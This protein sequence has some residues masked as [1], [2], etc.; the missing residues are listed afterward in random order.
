MEY[1]EKRWL[2]IF[3]LLAI[4]VTS[5][6]YALAFNQQ[7]DDWLFSG[8]LIGVED[9]NSYIAKMLRG[10]Q[11]DWLFESPYS[12]ED[13]SGAL[14]YLPYLLL[15]KLLGPDGQHD[16]LLLLFHVF[17]IVALVLLC[18]AS[19]SFL[20]FFLKKSSSRRLGIFL[21]TF[22]G[23]L[24]WIL[25]LIGQSNWL[26]SL[27]LEFY[28][29]ETFGFLAFFTLLHLALG[30]ALMLWGILLYLK[31]GTQRVQGRWII[32]LWLSMAMVHLLNAVIGLL[33]IGLHFIASTVLERRNKFSKQ[34]QTSN[35]SSSILFPLLGAGI[36][37][38]LNLYLLARDPYLQAWAAQNQIPSPHFLHYVLAYGLL[39]PFAI[40]G[41]RHLSKQEKDSSLLLITWLLAL[42]VLLYLPLGLQRRF[43]E[44]IWLVLVVLA[45]AAFESK[46]FSKRQRWK[47]IFAAAFPASLILLIGTM[48]VA[49]DPKPPVFYSKDEVNLFNDLHDR[50]ENND[51]VLSNYELGNLIP[52]WA[53]VR[54]IIGHGPESVGLSALQ[55]GIEAFLVDQ[56]VDYGSELFSSYDIDY[57]VAEGESSAFNSFGFDHIATYGDFLL[58]EKTSSGD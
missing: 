39:L 56:N 22:G 58:F 6:P 53:P 21:V 24:G 10:G 26:G 12:A 42:P 5:L 19:Y 3:I 40:I 15:G 51:L 31:S 1:K 4:I 2:L 14:L 8:F 54:V 32:L 52:A 37:I 20:S 29:P 57:I 11:G 43:A 49:G 30:R 38:V 55:P 18:L 50:A 47:W 46:R 28:S 35:K 9:G 33:V 34:V 23:G 17:R 48:Q 27:P 16:Q 25:L 13:Q 45:L 7:S 36:P 44:G 41:A